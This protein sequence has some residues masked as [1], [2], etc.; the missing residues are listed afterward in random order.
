VVNLSSGLGSFWAV[1]NPERDQ[2][3]YA[4]VVYSATKAAVSMLTVQYAK[5]V[6][7]VKFNAAEPGYASTDFNNGHGQYTPEE[8]ARVIVRLATI[9]KNGPTGTFQELDGELA[10]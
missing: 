4:T 5:A 2:S 6:P 9:G 3:K 7:D 8:A 1:T 10:W